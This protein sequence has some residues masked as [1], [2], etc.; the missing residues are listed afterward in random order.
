MAILTCARDVRRGN[1][2]RSNPITY[3]ML[4]CKGK[5]AVARLRRGNHT[6]IAV[7]PRAPTESSS[8]THRKWIRWLSGIWGLRGLTRSPLG[9]MRLVQPCP[10]Y[11]ALVHALVKQILVH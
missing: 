9:T 8:V 11:D 6:K 4:P 3:V 2:V 7:R 10:M 1:E 5:K